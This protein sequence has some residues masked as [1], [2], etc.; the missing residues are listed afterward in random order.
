MLAAGNVR[1]SSPLL[2]LA[3][4]V[5]VGQGGC[6]TFPWSQ[7]FIG[8]EIRGRIQV[9][10][11]PYHA[12]SI[13]PSLNLFSPLKMVYQPIWATITNYPRR[14]ALNHK[15]LFLTV[16]EV[17]K[18]KIKVLADPVSDESCFL[19]WRQPSYCSL[20]WQGAEKEEISNLIHGGLTYTTQLLPKD[21]TSKCH[22]IEEQ[23]ATYGFGGDINIQAIANGN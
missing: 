1:P 10:L 4:K 22:R 8:G 12:A 14:G 21:S 11:L 7:N 15:H 19:V 17:G 6:M 13:C 5:T 2:Y 23:A 3:G 9:L 20:T 18:S 16:L